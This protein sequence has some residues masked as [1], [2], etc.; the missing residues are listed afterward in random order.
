MSIVSP[1]ASARSLL[2]PK[3]KGY[4]PS[5]YTPTLSSATH[6]GGYARLVASAKLPTDDLNLTP[7]ELFTKYT[8]SEVRA[9]Q[10]RLRYI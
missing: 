1:V 9:V 2:S 4:A 6:T 3:S 5:E 8:V 7:E 10:Q